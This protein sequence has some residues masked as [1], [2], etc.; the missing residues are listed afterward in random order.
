MIDFDFSFVGKC[1][2]WH[3]KQGAWHFI[4]LPADKS[5]E[6]RF[7]AENMH[8]KRRGWGAMKVVVTIGNTTWETSIFPDSKAN[9]YL[10][11]LK[12]EIRK[13]KGIAAGDDVKVRLQASV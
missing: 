8:E 12:A 10:L 6:I 9:A 7:F 13:K 3:G 5:E 2:L 11:P 4:T 1:W